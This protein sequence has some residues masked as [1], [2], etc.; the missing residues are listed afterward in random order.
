M[1]WSITAIF[2]LLFYLLFFLTFLII[3]TVAP[4]YLVWMNLLLRKLKMHHQ[5][6]WIKLGAPSV[7][8]TSLHNIRLVSRWLTSKEYLNLDD[9][10]II[11]KA[12][13]CRILRLIF[14]VS[15]VIFLILYGIFIIYM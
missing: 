14:L 9:E 11:Q 10:Q 2:E 8:N 3:F 13:I 15:F 6:V 12:Q 7:R 1:I 4:A 5:D